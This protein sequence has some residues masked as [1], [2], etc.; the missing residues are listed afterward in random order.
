MT[1]ARFFK[2]DLM[3][4]LLFAVFA[5][6]YYDT[7]LDKGPLN[8]HLWRQTDCLSMTENYANG[9]AFGTKTAPYSEEKKPLFCSGFFFFFFFTSKPLCVKQK[10]GLKSKPMLGTCYS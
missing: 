9:A 8:V 2:S 5:A 7:V 6:F 3:F 10:E 1:K 4:V